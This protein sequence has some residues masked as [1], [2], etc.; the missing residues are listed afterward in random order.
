M[1]KQTTEPP[2][3]IRISDNTVLNGKFYARY[4][5]LPVERIED[6]PEILRPLVVWGDL[7]KEE[8]E[9]PD[10]SQPRNVMF[11]MN[12]LYQVDPDG[13]LGRQV[14]RRVQRQI[15]QMEADAQES[16]WIEDA[17]NASE[18]PPEIAEDLQ[19][20]HD[21]AVAFAKAQAQ[22]DANRAD[23][24]ADS[25]IAEQAPVPLFVRK[26]SRHYAQANKTRL[27]PG[28]PVFVRQ[29]SGRFECIGEV[30]GDCQLPDPPTIV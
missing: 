5:P 4:E 9:E 7:E 20:K 26:G 8:A 23:E 10:D 29:P 12:E 13:R 2:A 1:P 22:V 6:L 16:D 14:Q 28:E 24:L 21:D 27:K 11:K 30:D 18:L 3:P 15:S 25:I 17:V 19:A